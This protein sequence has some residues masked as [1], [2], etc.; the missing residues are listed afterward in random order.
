MPTVKG[1][2]APRLPFDRD[3]PSRTEIRILLEKGW[4][5]TAA[6]LEPL[7][8]HNAEVCESLL[9][10]YTFEQVQK[11]PRQAVIARRYRKGTQHFLSKGYQCPACAQSE[12][13]LNF[14]HCPSCGIEL[15]WEN[16]KAHVVAFQKEQ[17][18]KM[19]RIRHLSGYEES[20]STFRNH[21]AKR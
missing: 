9:W 21:A 2:T 14:R 3:L 1:N 20:G 18:I 4:G 15:L 17:S 16:P 13:R 19:A 12:I 5:N 11:V 10:K 6:Y 8:E 7:F